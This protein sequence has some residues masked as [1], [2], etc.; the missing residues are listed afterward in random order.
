MFLLTSDEEVGSDGELSNS[1]NAWTNK[2]D[3]SFTFR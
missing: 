1:S 3:M 2:S